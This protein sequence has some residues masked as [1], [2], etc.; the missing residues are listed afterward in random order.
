MFFICSSWQQYTA[1]EWREIYKIIVPLL[2]GLFNDAK[3]DKEVVN[4]FIL[5]LDRYM[6]LRLPSLSEAQVIEL[7]NLTVKLYQRC[8]VVSPA[9]S[10]D[11]D[12][13]PHFTPSSCRHIRC[14]PVG[15]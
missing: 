8:Q 12:L 14:L 4:L 3:F 13:R 5:A 7:Q 9:L 2:P 11:H 1:D 6:L 15:N 10:Q